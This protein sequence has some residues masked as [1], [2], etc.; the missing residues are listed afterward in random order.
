MLAKLLRVVG[1]L[2][3]LSGL[4]AFM[5]WGVEELKNPQLM[6]VNQVA[7]ASS[8]K[9]V[10]IEK[11]QDLIR[12]YG[13]AGFIHV[14]TRLIKEKLLREPWIKSAT[15][16]RIWPDT[17]HIK[18]VEQVAFARWGE[19]LLLNMEGE[20]FKPEGQEYTADLAILPALWGPKNSEFHVLTQY[21]SMNERLNAIGLEI[22]KISYD[23]RRAWRLVLN[24]GSS[25]VL[26]RND[27]SNRLG[28]FVRLYPNVLKT[29]IE[30]IHEIDMRY[31]NGLAVKWRI[32]ESGQSYNTEY[33][34]RESV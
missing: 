22:K 20:L 9:H 18:V 1:T 8:F 5:F 3:V 31:S 16:R 2:S 29:E 30:K 27:T 17:L 25:L 6:P 14:D 15:V 34:K 19:S 33:E 4:S 11:I 12:P 32:P 26:G 13:K 7:V 10:S 21:K 23:E 28:R 24:N